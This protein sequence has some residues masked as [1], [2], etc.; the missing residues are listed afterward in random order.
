MAAA[1]PIEQVVII[2]K[3]N[4]TFDCYF[5]TFPGADGVAGLP[6][7]LDQP[8]SDPRHDHAAW[9]RRADPPPHGARRE[10]Y[11]EADIPAY[12]AYAR[13]FTLCDNYFTAVASQSEPN[14]LML[15]A[16]ASPIIDNSNAHRTY[17]PQPP[18]DIPSLPASLE[19]KGLTWRNYGGFYHQHI[20]ALAGSPH[21]VSSDDFDKDIAAKAL[22]SVSWLYASESHGH[23]RGGGQSEHP[24][25]SVSAGMRWTVD[26]VNKLA[27]S[28]YW[29]STAIFIT[30]DD[31]GGW[32]DHVEPPAAE[33]WTGG[34]PQGYH[35]SQFRFGP[36]VGCLVLSPYAK[37]NHISSVT[38]GPTA[39][40]S[41]ASLV[42]FCGTVFGLAPLGD[43]DAAA[44]D[45]SDCFDFA[46]RRTDRPGGAPGR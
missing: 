9:L 20:A 37:R 29:D 40:R 38:S 12:F 3:E 26:R 14:H 31:W 32:F 23:G 24:T 39:V 30:W 25:D 43:I 22:P 45:M 8:P 35:N 33:K 6:R 42:R 27:N 4:H 1:M 13:Q 2:V 15:I 10:Q 46:H 18:F 44:D 19:A 28:P 16:A 17:Q 11:L 5:G 7:A 36:R 34:G 41:H 21:N